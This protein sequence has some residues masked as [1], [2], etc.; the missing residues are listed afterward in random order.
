MTIENDIEQISDLTDNHGKVYRMLLD[1]LERPLISR[2]LDMTGGNQLK[3]ANILGIN[4]NT[5]R[6]KIKRLGINT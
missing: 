3:A 2:V 6:A 1:K 5:L 4:R